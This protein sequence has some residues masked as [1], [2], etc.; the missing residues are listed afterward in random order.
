MLLK[1]VLARL[2]QVLG[3]VILRYLLKSLQKSEKISPHFPNAS[4]LNFW[5]YIVTQQ[6]HT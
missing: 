1:F 4:H 5:N 3:N 6:H 2:L